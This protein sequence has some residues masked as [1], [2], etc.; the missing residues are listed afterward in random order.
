MSNRRDRIN[1]A[2]DK[3]ESQAPDSSLT[4]LDS[5]MFSGSNLELDTQRHVVKSLSIFQ[6]SPDTTQPRRAMP[7]EIRTLWLASEGN[8]D[9]LFVAWLRKVQES[10]PEFVLDHFMQQPESEEGEEETTNR[11]KKKQRRL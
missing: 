8:T 6:I 11:S 10:S 3:P 4:A 7:S 9:A 1:K 2:F 5:I